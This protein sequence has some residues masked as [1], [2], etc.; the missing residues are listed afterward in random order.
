M[1]VLVL[2]VLQ[3]AGLLGLIL[4][5]SLVEGYG[6][7]LSLGTRWPYRED[8]LALAVKGDPEAWHRIL[9]T[10]L[11]VNAVVLAVLVGDT[12][13]ISG[14]ILIAA[15]A[16]L[17]LATHGAPLV[18]MIEPSRQRI[19][20]AV[21]GRSNCAGPLHPMPPIAPL[22]SPTARHQSP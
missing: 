19:F 13:T 8:L 17:G 21:L 15:T 6:Y 2:L 7:G 11:G 20:T 14:L 16:L 3:T 4:L 18:T 1:L 12:N 22:P 9:A 5:G 10:T